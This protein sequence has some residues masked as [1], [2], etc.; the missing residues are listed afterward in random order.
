MTQDERIRDLEAQVKRL[1]D[2]L[3][4]RSNEPEMTASDAYHHCVDMIEP[5]VIHNPQGSE[6]GDNSLCASV[7]ESL[8]FLID[9]WKMTQWVSIDKATDQEGDV[10]LYVPDLVDEDFNPTGVIEGHWQDVDGWVGAVWCPVQDYWK[11]RAVSPTH[12]LR[13]YSP[14]TQGG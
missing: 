4:N 11:Y 3:Q 13:K 2:E 10:L 6:C 8:R 12:F 9:H 1:D 5:H 7:C 14:K